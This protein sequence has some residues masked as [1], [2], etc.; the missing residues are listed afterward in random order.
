MTAAAALLAQN[1]AIK[2]T[3]IQRNEFSV[4]GR[5]AVV[6]QVEIVPGGFAGMHTHAG[7]E[8]GYVTEGELE[9]LIDGQ[10]ARTIKTGESFMVPAGARHNGHNKGTG[11]LKFVGVYLIDKGTPLATPA[12]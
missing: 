10:P 12:P 4:P 3:V 8:I 7:E 11:Q 9:L 1:P 2:R 6:A 5:E